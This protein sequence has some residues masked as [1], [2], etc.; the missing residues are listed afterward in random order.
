MPRVWG[1]E[2]SC[3]GRILG[4]GRAQFVFQN[5]ESLNL[6]LRRGPWSFND[7]MLSVHRW[8]PNIT[9]G[10]MKIIPF[11]V[12]IRGIPLICLTTEMIRYVGNNLGPVLEVNFDENAAQVEFVRVQIAWNFDSPLRF[13]R[14]F[15]FDNEENTVIKFRFERLRNFCTK[16]GSLKHDLKE[17]TLAFDAVDDNSDGSSGDDDDMDR[18]DDRN[19]ETSEADT[20]E[21]VDPATLI[22]GLG[23]EQGM[24]PQDQNFTETSIPS[25]FED[26]ELTAERLRYLHAKMVKDFL[27]EN[28]QY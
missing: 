20:L 7:W 23:C 15:Q 2:N 9:D 6:V 28:D 26:T 5:E 10:E 4:N 25:A 18:G 8:F 19:Q 21:T 13:Q 22:L 17:C 24:T 27:R 12:Q 16:C 11:W 3:N 1:F 14:M